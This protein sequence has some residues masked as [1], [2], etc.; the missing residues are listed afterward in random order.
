MDREQEVIHKQMEATRA[1]L[2]DKL[3]ALESQVS[4]TVEAATN[5][6]ESTKDAVAGTVE[7]VTNTVESVKDTVQETIEKVTETVSETVGNVTEQFQ[8]TVKSVTETFNLNLQCERHPW[9]VFGGAVAVGCLG[10]LLLGGKKHLA[11]PEP[12]RSGNGFSS[13]ARPKQAPTGPS[14]VGKAASAV[15]SAASGV[16]G[17]L[18]GWLGEQL[19]QF[20][21]LAIG[22]MMGVVRDL[23][24]RSLPDNIKDRVAEEVDK[25][26][27]GLGG[28]P[29][30]GSVLP[31]PQE[32]EAGASSEEGGRN[33]EPPAQY[34]ALG[35]PK[36]ASRH[37]GSLPKSGRN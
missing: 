28:E 24:T 22:A 34:G 4:G 18:G 20:K 2:T 15:G 3:S 12:T 26:T 37:K 27:K 19:G 23:A 7:A 9:V 10:G 11:P 6:V 21:G 32:Q 31:Q 30:Q 35:H 36:T 33:P 13:H 5:A 25:L 17:V 29:I 1:G 8:A 14:V 16:G